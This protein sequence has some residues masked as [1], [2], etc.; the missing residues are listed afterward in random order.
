[1]SNAT[2]EKVGRTDTPI[3]GPRRLL[4]CGFS[5]PVQPK[6]QAVLKMAGLDNVPVVWAGADDRD[7]TLAALFDQIGGYGLGRPS[8][9]PR[10]IIVAGIFEKQLHLLMSA[11]RQAGMKNALW[12]ALTPTSQTW[13]LGALLNELAAERDQLAARRR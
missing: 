12:A 13:T 1:M 3:Y 4:V 10:A 8:D 6:F 5:A 11:C 2:F 7:E 9:L